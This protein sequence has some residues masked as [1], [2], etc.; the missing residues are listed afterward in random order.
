MKLFLLFL[1]ILAI[2]PVYGK[3]NNVSFTG[4]LV[5]PPPCH[6]N[7]K[8]NMNVHFD[9]VGVNKINGVNYQ[10]SIDYILTCEDTP[11]WKMALKLTGEA[12]VF[13]DGTIQSN[14]AGLGIKVTINEQPMELNESFVISAANLPRLKAVPVKDIGAVLNE[15]P[16]TASATL[17][18]QY[19]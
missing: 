19:Q 7:D 14:V 17:L 15:G 10:Q 11:G 1:S 9:K 4:T 8:G 18:A 3:E 5:E 12:A 2:L 16:F 13:S 6:I